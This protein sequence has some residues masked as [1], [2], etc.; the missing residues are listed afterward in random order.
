MG[1]GG[2][3]AF[4]FCAYEKGKIAKKIIAKSFL[5]LLTVKAFNLNFFSIK[6]HDKQLR[7]KTE[8]T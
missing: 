5:T 2:T 4:T 1:N 7:N 6:L 3:I 8:T